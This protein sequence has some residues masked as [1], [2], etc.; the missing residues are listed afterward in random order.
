M[1][2]ITPEEVAK[3]LGITRRAVYDLLRTGQLKGYRAGRKWVVKPEG[4]EAFRK[5]AGTTPASVAKELRVSRHTVYTWLLSGRLKGQRI[6]KRWLIKPEDVYAFLR[7]KAQDP[8]T[9]NRERVA[10]RQP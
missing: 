2:Y 3:E 7:R 1:A 8:N 6:G 5:S 10:N 9:R 4:V